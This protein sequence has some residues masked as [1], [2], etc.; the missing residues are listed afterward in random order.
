M[1]KL[2]LIVLLKTTLYIFIGIFIII[3]NTFMQDVIHTYINYL[4]GAAAAAGAEA[5][6][7]PFASV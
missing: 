4:V 3:G 7:T 1:K 5:T 6:T 2:S